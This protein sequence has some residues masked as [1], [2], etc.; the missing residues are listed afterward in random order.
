MGTVEFTCT[1]NLQKWNIATE[2]HGINV[3]KVL[4]NGEYYTITDEII[5]RFLFNLPNVQGHKFP[6][7]SHLANYKVP[8]GYMAVVG[9]FLLDD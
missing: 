2:V 5:A 1:G 3:P 6:T 9:Q 4:L 8:E 7:A